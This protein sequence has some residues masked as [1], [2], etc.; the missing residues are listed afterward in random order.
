MK[1][2]A[3]TLLSAAAAATLV[4]ADTWKITSLDQGNRVNLCARQIQSCQ[5][6]CGGADQA[7]MAFCNETTLAWGCGCATRTPKFKLWDWPV[8]AADCQGS[9]QAC[10]NNC[11]SKSDDRNKCFDNCEKTHKCNTEDAPVSYTEST[12]VATPPKYVGPAVSYKGDKLGDLGDGNTHKGDSSPSSSSNG[13][14]KSDAKDASAADSGKSATSS[15]KNSGVS[16]KT[17]G[18]TVF[19][20]AVAA[21]A[22]LAF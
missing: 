1:F 4:S 12:D 10:K 8:P 16:V 13:D 5:N 18:L 11:N 9:A 22:A 7:P 21:A 14:S 3:S 2:A 20:A 6:D 15:S 19:G 17:A